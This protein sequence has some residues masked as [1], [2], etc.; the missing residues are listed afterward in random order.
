MSLGYRAIGALVAS[1]LPQ[2]P[3]VSAPEKLG[4]H[5][6]ARLLLAHLHGKRQD[7]TR[8]HAVQLALVKLCRVGMSLLLVPG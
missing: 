2:Y 1:V 4:A 7:K 6:P 8:V 5:L 3:L